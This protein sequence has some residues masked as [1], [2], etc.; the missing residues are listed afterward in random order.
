M[1][2]LLTQDMPES[3]RGDQHETSLP[4]SMNYH[5]KVEVTEGVVP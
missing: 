3:V 2:E 4:D 5:F 1:H